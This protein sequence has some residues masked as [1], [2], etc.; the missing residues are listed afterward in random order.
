MPF[1]DA[2][3]VLSASLGN[4]CIRMLLSIILQAYQGM[5]AASQGHQSLS[6]SHFDN[7]KSLWDQCS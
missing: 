4:I 5:W 3:K 1:Y 2:G 6:R 7:I